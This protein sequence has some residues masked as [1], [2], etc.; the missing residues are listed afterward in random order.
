MENC[1]KTIGVWSKPGEHRCEKLSEVIHCRNCE[2]F[3]RAGRNLLEQGLPEEYLREWTTVLAARKPADLVGTLS[4]LIF[5][6]EQEWLALP[7]LLFAEVVEHAPTHRVPHRNNP[8]LIGLANVHGEICLCVSMRQ[9]LGI[10][11][12]DAAKDSLP[13]VAPSSRRQFTSRLLVMEKEGER[14][15]FAVDEIHGIHRIHPSQLQSPPV[16]LSKSGAGFAKAVFDWER[17]HVGLLD[18]D[19]L[20]YKLTRSVQ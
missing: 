13:T 2:T 5:R 8:V 14:W 9:L 10:A 18:E 16:S 11:T 7:S 17:K 12:K 6:L 1:W 3:T 15:L 19:L 4:V 20:L